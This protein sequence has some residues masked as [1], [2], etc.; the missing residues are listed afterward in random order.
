ME[1]S[2]TFYMWLLSFSANKLKE[3]WSKFVDKVKCKKAKKKKMKK[4]EQDLMLRV[5]AIQGDA[6]NEDECDSREG[7]LHSLHDSDRVRLRHLASN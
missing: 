4:M 5:M 7:S 6:S 2:L 3:G 1:S